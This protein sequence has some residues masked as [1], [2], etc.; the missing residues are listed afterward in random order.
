MSGTSFLSAT[1]VAEA[2]GISLSLSVVQFLSVMIAAGI[3][4]YVI[5]KYVWDS[6]LEFIKKRNELANKRLSEAKSKQ[7]AA[8]KLSEEKQNELIEIK[9]SKEQILSET[10]NDGNLQKM[11]IVD[12]AREQARLILK[13]AH[14]QIDKET[15]EANKTI[16]KN[17]AELVSALT[18]KFVAESITDEDQVKL[19]RQA[20]NKVGND[21]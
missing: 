19:Y 9:K 11:Q 14:E 3:V 17:L 21:E 7:E 16:E 20:L 5:R 15:E 8:E 6:Y 13:K 10:K 1:D 4:I 2:A 12:D 18:E